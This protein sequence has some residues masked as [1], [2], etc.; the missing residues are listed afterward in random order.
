MK[1]VTIHDN[2]D[3]SVVRLEELPKPYL[4]PQDVM[5]HVQSAALNHLDIWVRRGRPGVQINAPHVLGSDASGVVA[6]TGSAVKKVKPGDEVLINPGISCGRCEMCQRGEQ[7]LCRTFG[8]LGMNY[9]GTFAEYVVVPSFNVHPKPTHLSFPESAAIPLTYVTAWRMLMTRAKVK[10]G[11]SVLIHGI[12]GG[13][14][15][16]GLDICRLVGVETV[17]TSSSDEKLERAKQLG[18][19]HTINYR[20]TEDLVGK[21]LDLTGGRGVDVVLDTCG[22]ATWPIDFAAIRRGGRIVLCGITTGAQVQ[23]NL[24]ALYWNQL[25]VMG[26]TMGSNRD[27]NEMLRAVIAKQIR[28]V[29]DSVAPLEQ[30]TKQMARMETGQQFGKLVLDLQ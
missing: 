19:D 10:P 12:G 29:I 2:G 5:V 20:T 6:E 30:A 27:F 15:L 26:S 22:A 24:Q 1:A 18:A 21:I 11:E 8:I 3:L 16:A 28:P 7:S 13:V 14:A 25:T 23:T 17:V 9:P 4:G